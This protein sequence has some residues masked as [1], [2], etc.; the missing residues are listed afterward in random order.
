MS[1]CH[2]HLI[3]AIDEFSQFIKA[4]GK[5]FQCV[6]VVCECVSLVN[7]HRYDAHEVLVDVARN[8]VVVRTCGVSY[9]SRSAASY[10]ID[11]S[12]EVDDSTDERTLCIVS[13]LTVEVLITVVNGRNKDVIH[14]ELITLLCAL[15]N[16]IVDRII[17]LS[18]IHIFTITRSETT[19]AYSDGNSEA[20]EFSLDDF[21][22]VLG[23][24]AQFVCV[25]QLLTE[26]RALNIVDT[27]LEIDEW[28]IVFIV[29]NFRSDSEELCSISLANDVTLKQ[30]SALRADNLSFRIILS[31]SGSVYARHI[32]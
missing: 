10:Q 3:L 28:F 30:I 29:L 12:V 4:L 23:L 17:F 27:E 6:V 18:A 14:E 26:R 2:E 5:F 15:E 9:E 7:S 21:A 16:E 32:K 13:P 8:S 1:E 24:S 22:D 20:I 19:D 11:D 31:Q 25:D